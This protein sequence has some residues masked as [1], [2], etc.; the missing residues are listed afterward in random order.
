MNTI[1][2]IISHTGTGVAKL[3]R[4]F[5]KGY[6]NHCSIA[7]N[8]DFNNLF[9]FSRRYKKYWFTGCF[10]IETMNTIKDKGTLDALV[11]E[12]RLTDEEFDTIN[13]YL[14]ELSKRYRPYNYIGAVTILFGKNIKSNKH[15]LCSTFTAYIL[16]MIH[17]TH[18]DKE[19]YLYTPMDILKLLEEDRQA[20]LL[21]KNSIKYFR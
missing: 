17:T 1:Q 9:S 14:K 20:Y 16:K 15:H 12:I 2:I 13:Q 3:I 4:F 19:F 11:Y 8:R 7:L 10:T 5:T 18:L 21:E 6:Y